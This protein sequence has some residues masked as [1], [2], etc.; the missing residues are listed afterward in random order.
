M[1]INNDEQA[2]KFTNQLNHLQ[3]FIGTPARDGNKPSLSEV[4]ENDRRLLKQQALDVKA[5]KQ[6]LLNH[7]L[8]GLSN[9]TQT[10]F[11]RM[12]KARVN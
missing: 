12:T 9:N 5:P 11:R 7:F 3:S 6:S 8:T 1:S 2:R 10:V 4:R